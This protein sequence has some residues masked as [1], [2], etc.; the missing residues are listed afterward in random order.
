MK[1]EQL[2]VLLG[3]VRNGLMPT[4][5][6]EEMFNLTLRVERPVHSVTKDGEIATV[7]WHTV[8]ELSGALDVC[9]RQHTV[10]SNGSDDAAACALYCLGDAQ[11]QQGDRVTAEDEKG[12]QIVLRVTSVK[13]PMMRYRYLIAWCTPSDAASADDA[14]HDSS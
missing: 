13:N 6:I 4:L 14:P 5:P 11:L 12:A 10:P 2:N 7:G 9:N 1:D 3:Q 8:D